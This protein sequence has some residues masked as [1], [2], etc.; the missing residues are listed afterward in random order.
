MATDGYIDIN[1]RMKFDASQVQRTT[2]ELTRQLDNLFS[3]T[4]DKNMSASFQRLQNNIEKTMLKAEDLSADLSA[5]ENKKVR[6]AEFDELAKKFAKADAE[7]QKLLDKQDEME[8]MGKNHGKA[9]DDLNAKQEIAGRKVKEIR[10]DMMYLVQEGKAF[11]LGRDTDEYAQKAQQL[12][13][14]N[15]KLRINTVQVETNKEYKQSLVGTQQ[16]L[17]NA[18]MKFASTVAKGTRGAYNFY[19]NGLQKLKDGMTKGKKAVDDTSKSFTRGLKKMLMYS[20]GIRG[21]FRLFNKLRG[22]VKDAFGVMAKQ[23]DEVNADLS[24]MKNSFTQFKHSLA[25]AFQPLLSVIAPI[26]TQIM[27]LATKASEAVGTFFATLTG[28]KYIY[29]AT[30]ATEDYSESLDKNTKSAEK[31]QKQLGHYDKLNVISQDKDKG[32]DDDS[33]KGGF[34]KVAIDP[35]NAVSEFAKK[36]MKAWKEADFTEIGSIL[37]TKLKNALEKIP[38]DGIKEVAKKIGKSIGTLINGF[39][40]VKGLGITIGKTIAEALNTVVLGIESFIDTT[41]WDSVGKFIVDTLNGFIKKTDWSKLGITI[42]KGITA[43]FTVGDKFWNETDFKS[44]GSGLATTLVNTIKNTDFSKVSSTISGII[45]APMKA[46]SGAMDTITWDDAWKNFKSKVAEFFKGIKWEDIFSTLGELSGKIVKALYSVVKDIIDDWNNYFQPYIK[47]M[48]GDV[49]KG[50][51]LGILMALPNLAVWVAK[52]IIK[53]FIDGFKKGFGIHSPSTVMMQIGGYIMQGLFNGLKEGWN[54]I[55]KF[56]KKLPSKIKNVFTNL[57]NTLGTLFST[58]FD[59]IKNAFNGVKT[60]FTGVKNTIKEVFVGKDGKGGIISALTGAFSDAWK[61][62]KDIFSKGGKLF[63]GMVTGVADVF[64]G[65]V[66]DLIDGI[67]SII[68]EPFDKINDMLNDIRNTKIPVIN[69]KPFKGLWDDDP[70]KIPK[71]PHI[72]KLAQGAVI[73]PNKEF[74]AVL[75]DQKSGTNIETPLST[76]IDAFEQA[77]A[78]HKTAGTNGDI[79]VQINSREIARAVWSENDKKYKQSGAFVPRYS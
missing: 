72:P 2:S 39:V 77:L 16:K 47:K 31:N 68:S 67:N 63:D 5:L 62:I 30:E 3:R 36:L 60:F 43:L 73:P 42:G 53:P 33:K 65:L 10:N 44:L 19:K 22:W 8:A 29:K 71:I 24:A 26:F 74:L 79:V 40:E 78:K 34:E 18:T 6:T 23:S 4:A 7:F 14:L 15:N 27:Q 28:Q 46:L 21:L 12:E 51:L 58:A 1:A 52:K 56:V 69:K 13:D 57:P 9:W 11:V 48:G 76:M 61:G 64:R 70:I 37:G 50:I 25:T 32:S 75:G 38:W 49:T 54:K 55:I 66:N 17:T 35:T 41:H 59:R 45:T 20:L